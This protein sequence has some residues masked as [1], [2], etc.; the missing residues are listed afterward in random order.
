MIKRKVLIQGVSK[1]SKQL[2]FFMDEVF[3]VIAFVDRN[4]KISDSE[5]DGV[6]IY[7]DLSIL[8]NLDYDYIFVMAEDY[9][10]VTFE[11]HRKYNIP[12][13]KMISMRHVHQ[14][15]K[16]RSFLAY[17]NE[18]YRS[19]VPGSIAEVGVDY[20]D[21]AKYLNLYFSDRK[22]YLF[23][24][25][26]GFDY[27][28]IEFE[29]KNNTMVTSMENAYKVRSIANDVLERMFYPNQCIAKP[30]YF[31]ESLDGL[32]D[33]FAFVHID[34]DLQKPIL[35][36]LDYF[37]PRLSVGGIISVHDYFNPNFPGVR[38]VVREF[39]EKNN[40]R[41]TPNLMSG[42]AVFCK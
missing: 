21:T 8:S 13:E 36:A 17:A 15:G 30:G 19:N 7:T 18:I 20:G 23:D 3:D 35:C 32:E 31:P 41:F 16:Q 14:Y 40:V 24:T 34:C 12:Y 1:K 26:Y 29:R 38:N 22:L 11:Y 28:D 37:Y 42:S 5:F 27:R 25:F 6:P 10:G 33:I 4:K 39:S 9:C 2:K